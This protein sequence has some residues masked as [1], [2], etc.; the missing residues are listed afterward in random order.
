MRSILRGAAV[1]ALALALG[2]AP[3][4]AVNAGA[5]PGTSTIVDIVVAPD[6]KFD[7]L[8]AAVIK[9]GLV[10]AL[11]STDNQYTVFAPTDAAFVATFR[12]ILG[13]TTLTEAD[14]IAFINAGGVDQALGDGTLATILLFHVTNGRRTAT[15]V[16]HA[17][18]YHMLNGERLTR[19][20]LFAAGIAA[21][22]I[23][24]SNGVIHVINSVLIP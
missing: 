9:A 16:I 5:K 13:D 21:T 3:V 18:Q 19:T 23:S 8:Q 7:V 20:Q 17:P 14:V 2:A 15:S 10:G 22:D 24:A 4:F 12:S 11:S 6:G 1:A